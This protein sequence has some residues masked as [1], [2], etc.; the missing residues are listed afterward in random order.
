MGH[1]FFNSTLQKIN[2]NI[3][4]AIDVSTLSKNVNSPIS[5]ITCL[6]VFIGILDG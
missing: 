5:L 3:G 6:I 1:F 2:I 4:N